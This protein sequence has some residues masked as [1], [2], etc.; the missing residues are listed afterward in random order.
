MSNKKKLVRAKFRDSVFARDNYQCIICGLK[1]DRKNPE[2]V[3]DAHHINDRNDMPHGGYVPK[4]GASLCKIN[5]NCH[6]KAEKR[7]PGCEPETLYK[8]IKSSYEEA[9]KQS[10][11][12]LSD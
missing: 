10:E 9:V 3:L 7:E 12:W 5:K 8:I 2:E 1:A 6:L 4:N 11:E